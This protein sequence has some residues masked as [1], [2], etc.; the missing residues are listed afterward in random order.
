MGG[1]GAEWK[2]IFEC[3]VWDDERF[4]K[5]RVVTVAQDCECK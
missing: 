5:W 1:G 3:S 2:V 4:W